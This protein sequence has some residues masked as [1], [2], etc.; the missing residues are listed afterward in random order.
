M[1]VAGG[2]NTTQLLDYCTPPEECR[3]RDHCGVCNGDGLSCTA[4][5]CSCES[6]YVIQLDGCAGRSFR[7]CTFHQAG[8]QA[9]CNT[10]FEPD[11]AAFA[12]AHPGQSF[13]KVPTNCTDAAFSVSATGESFDYCT[14]P[15]NCSYTD[16]CGVCGGD[17]SSCSTMGCQCE[18]SW[19]TFL[20]GCEGQVF[21][22]CEFHNSN[23]QPCHPLLDSSAADFVANRP[24]LSFCA[25]PA[26]CPTP[27]SVGGVGLDYCTPA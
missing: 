23:S 1:E 9:P 4:G 8:S 22:G 14:P 25:V 17:G 6:S 11:A 15:S 5:G 3:Y 19:T 26:D 20:P 27:F 16:A 10:V 12:A 7:G 18:E 13:C 21:S 2:A 24:G